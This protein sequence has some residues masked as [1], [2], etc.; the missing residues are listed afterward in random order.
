MTLQLFL[1]WMAIGLV[2]GWLASAI[3]GGGYGVV[4]DIIVGLVGSFIGGLI[5]NGLH[6]SAPWAGLPG[7]IFVAFVGALV[8]LGILRLVHTTSARRL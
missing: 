3:L 5:F 8:L 4:G 2:A 1:I 7:T 6:I